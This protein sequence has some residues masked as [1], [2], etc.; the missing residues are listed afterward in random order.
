M[1]KSQAVHS[2][3]NDLGASVQLWGMPPQGHILTAPPEVHS[4]TFSSLL[5][6]LLFFC[7]FHPQYSINNYKHCEEIYI[8][9]SLVYI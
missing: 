8:Y 3:P 5:L 1:D 9:I 4:Q 6:L 2:H 7:E